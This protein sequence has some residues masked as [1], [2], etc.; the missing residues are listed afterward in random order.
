VIETQANDVSAYIPTNVISI[1]DGQIFLETDLF[2]QGI[3]PAVNVG[4]S[5]SRVGSAAQTK[6]MKKVAGRIKGELAQYR[7]MAAF[8]QFGSDLDAVTQR[9]LNR[10]ARL[11]ELLKQP[12]FSPLKMEEQVVVIYA[13]VNGYLDPLPVNRVRAFEDG[14][15]GAVRSR[16]PE[17]LEDI[18]TSRDLPDA[19]AA[20]LK[21]AVDAFAKSFS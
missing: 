17:I 15:L 12:Q 13:G 1:T 16:N 7:E 3:R 4:L 8:A 9:L 11:T 14:L 20:K 18:R 5:V 19:A 6:A 10:G 2:Y 21:E